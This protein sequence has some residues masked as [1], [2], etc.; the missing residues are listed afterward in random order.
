MITALLDI[1][2]LGPVLVSRHEPVMQDPLKLSRQQR[3]LL[4]ALAI[5]HPR[6]A[7]LAWLAGAMGLGAANGRNGRSAEAS[8]AESSVHSSERQALHTRIF[9]LRQLLGQGAIVALG[10]GEGATYRLEVPIEAIDA[11]RFLAA[12]EEGHALLA[13]GEIELARERLGAA[14][15]L[16]RGALLA[17]APLV[18]PLPIAAAALLERRS[19]AVEAFADASIRAGDAASVV[20]RLH[21]LTSAEHLRE[22]AWALLVSA[23]LAIGNAGAARTAA[24]AALASISE[25]GVTPG[26]ELSDAAERA[27]GRRYSA[28]VTRNW[29]AEPLPPW[30]A[31]ATEAGPFVGRAREVDELLAHV[32]DARA[33]HAALVVVTGEAGS[34]KTRLIAEVARIAVARGTRVW[35]AR[36]DP[37]E[38]APHR[39]LMDLLAAVIPAASPEVAGRVL[40]GPLGA[41]V[42]A[43]PTEAGSEPAAEGAA[44]API[45]AASDRWRLFDDMANLVVDAVEGRPTLVA[46]DDLQWTTPHTVLFIRELV[47]ARPDLPLVILASVRDT[48]LSQSWVELLDELNRLAACRWL[49][50]RGLEAEEI[51][52]L[53]EVAA[54]AELERRS[55][56]DVAVALRRAT[57]G[58][59]FLLRQLVDDPA[60]LEEVA[61]GAIPQ[62]ASVAVASHVGL[63]PPEARGVLA[64]ASLI[65]PSFDPRL[66]VDNRDPNLDA[67]LDA[68]TAAEAARLVVRE[69]CDQWVFRHDLIREA[70]AQTLSS[71]EQ[72]RWHLLIA[73][74]LER[75]KG[76][77]A[78][79][80][81]ELARH[82]QLAAPIVDG[83]RALS[84]A[85]R[86]ARH[87]TSS[88]DFGLAAKAH[89]MVAE[90][91]APEEAI[92]ARLHAADAVLCT[93]DVEGARRELTQAAR[94]AE[95]EMRPE[96]LARVAVAAGQLAE[97]LGDRLTADERA[98]IDSAR[99]RM[100]AGTP[101]A[102]GALSDLLYLQARDQAGLGEL[103]DLLRR[104]APTV[105]PALAERAFWNVQ[106]QDRAGLAALLPAAGEAGS[107]PAYEVARQVHAIETGAA[108]F[109]GLLEG[110]GQAAPAGDAYDRWVTSG[111][112]STCLASS[113]QFPEAAAA[114]DRALAEATADPPR[115][116][117]STVVLVNYFLQMTAAQ[118]LRATDVSSGIGHNCFDALWSDNPPA[119]RLLLARGF[120]ITQDP[121]AADAFAAVCDDLLAGRHLTGSR[122]IQVVTMVE[123]AERL[124][125]AE[126]L[127][128]LYGDMLPWRDW[129]VLYRH[130]IYHGAMGFH[131]GLAALA[132][133]QPGDAIAWLERGVEEHR[134][135]GSPQY[136]AF[137]LT[138]L[139]AALTRYGRARDG[140]RV[141]EAQAEAEGIAARLGLPSTDVRAALR[142]SYHSRP[143]S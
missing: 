80:F 57:A 83:S 47:Q 11:H 121:R 52:A 88:L 138:A 12:D 59:P 126:R 124:G 111:W 78:S 28:R 54:R 110:W 131:L 130:T 72:A 96:L 44:T 18:S 53:P 127:S 25:V 9:R 87:A 58:N 139:A 109:P 101:G 134:R 16:W 73:R 60:T 132:L 65:G 71:S 118:F 103:A 66:L 143:A 4:G 129:H 64:G 140:R 113:G 142:A 77:D 23:H 114:A 30:L 136:L 63:L 45:D 137:S 22:H 26:P 17:D 102:P 94:A 112:L 106:P 50:L 35:G 8:G 89:R 76:G 98:L 41:L 75:D 43:G 15:A 116:V 69:A 32:T 3:Q 81:Y 128:R 119:F 10:R 90:L 104:R 39:P 48:L 133:D 36:A 20:E 1:G 37:F 14:L 42:Q 105:A 61:T 122:L 2:I 120:A 100:G 51:A 27:N 135:V 74:N 38:S 40:S 6:P 5:Q 55:A 24:A 107:A 123:V 115:E 95:I 29:P 82:F 49:Q 7:D 46:I 85:V 91:A 33:G 56:V 62:R 117:R 13:R 70:L 141:E 21:E 68:L 86:V 125:D 67:I 79:R 97:R 99:V 31:A 108:S 84:Y 34:G 92:T 93:G 19:A